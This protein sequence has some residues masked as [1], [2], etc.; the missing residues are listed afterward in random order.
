[1]H[2]RHDFLVQGKIMLRRSSYAVATARHSSQITPLI[3]SASPAPQSI[4]PAMSAVRI[5]IVD[6]DEPLRESC[7]SVFRLGGYE[8]LST[9]HG[10]EALAMLHRRAF[11]I[12]LVDLDMPRVDGLA[13]LKAALEINPATL[14]IVTTSTPDIE[15]SVNAM[16][17]G[18]WDY[19]P[20]PFSASHLHVLIG[21]AAHTVLTRRV[22]RP[23]ALA[24]EEDVS[25]QSLMLLG[26]TPV[27]RKAVDLAAKV[28]TTSAS[29][30]ITGESGCG[31]ELFA[32][33]IH[34]MSRRAGQPFVPVN[35]AALPEALLESEMFG[36]CKGAFTGAVRDKPGLL[37]TAD[38]GTLF[39]DELAEMPKA[40]QAKLLRVIQDGVVRR[41]GSDETNAVVDIRFIA[42]TNVDP[43]DAIGRGD[44]R[45]DL[46]YRLRVVRIHLPPLRER[47]EDIDALRTHFLTTF[48]RRHRE[49]GLRLPEFSEAAI[50]TMNAHSWPGN[51]RE[52]QNV[53]E[54]I[55]VLA[56][57]GSLIEPDDLT[58]LE[59]PARPD[60]SE[61]ALSADAGPYH[62]ARERLLARFETQYLTWLIARAAGNMSEAARIAGVDRTTLY[63]LLDRHGLYRSPHT[64]LI[65]G[66]T[67]IVP[68]EADHEL[69][70]RAL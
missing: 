29:V 45:E 56:A 34:G 48:W 26:T 52:L 28:A 63:R 40:S 6:D 35:C 53:I 22:E 57:P 42:A 38:G 46:Y 50:Q 61:L 67:A 64:K 1:M 69:M 17:L 31:K 10:D 19:L 16:R 11:D 55:A 62:P 70:T 12:M 25:L 8:V 7:T 9:G 59:K 41:V 15:A 14:V 39:L 51:V 2:E 3:S 43:E 30:F 36:H 60:E 5:F 65:S 20:K 13:L 54:N 58:M 68:A 66:S 32:H 4:A 47:P 24:I 23:L 27:F 33:Y 18:A 37:E 21:R 49:R 44:L